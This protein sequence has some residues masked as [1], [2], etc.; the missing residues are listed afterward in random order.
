M[1]ELVVTKKPLWRRIVRGLVITAVTL[2]L[3]ALVVRSVWGYIAAGQLRDEIARIRAAD[4]PL[5][6]KELEADLPKVEPADDAG[7]FYTA[8]L[9][10]MIG[11]D[12]DSLRKAYL[13]ASKSWPVEQL[14]DETLEKVRRLLADNERALGLI[15][16]GAALG[17]CAY[18]LGI[19]HGIGNTLKRLSPLRAAGKI[20]SLRTQY[21]AHQGQGEAA[22][23][24]AISMLKLTRVFDR[25]PVLIA[26][27]VKVGNGALACQDVGAILELSDPSDESLSQLQAALLDVD[28]PGDLQQAMLAERI[29]GLLIVRPAITDNMGIQWPVDEPARFSGQMP[30][31]FW[32]RPMLQNMAVG[33]L[34]DL[35]KVIQCAR[36]PWPD[37][38]D[39]VNSLEGESLLG[40]IVI[41]SLARSFCLT[42]RFIAGVRSARVAV[43]IERY[44]LEHDQLPASLSELVPTYTA[45]LPPDPFTGQDLIYRIEEGSYV[46]YSIGENRQD[47]DGDLDYK[48]DAER[49]EDRRQKDRGTR[50][51]FSKGKGTEKRRMKDEG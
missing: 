5:T 13:E 8:G 10:L 41:P 16:E 31:G 34:R 27:L 11:D 47:D 30:V 49:K 35:D 25:E 51:R 7:R 14:D 46:V 32:Q 38:L 44:R 17:G 24:S 33:Q 22:C 50:V 23:D 36:K 39:A 42:G 28:Q 26:H 1:S 48:K 45:T 37:A 15:D 43:M 12:A 21:L 19:N 6:F 9:A 40:R 18:G 3:L 4:E 20:L 2:F 29:L